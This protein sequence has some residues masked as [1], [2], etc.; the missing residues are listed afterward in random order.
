MIAA[1]RPL[2]NV[3]SRAEIAVKKEVAPWLLSQPF[4]KIF[5][6]S[7]RSIAGYE[8]ATHDGLQET[9][10]AIEA[11]HFIAKSQQ[12]LGSNLIGKPRESGDSD[13][14]DA[15][16]DLRIWLRCSTVQFLGRDVMREGKRLVFSVLKGRVLPIKRKT[17]RWLA[18]LIRKKTLSRDGCK[19]FLSKK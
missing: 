10:A 17:A 5:R 14:A 11:A 19:S 13:E 4:L 18:S 8:C 12:K 7:G 6:T 9:L 3:C 1:H 15:K 16:S 2:G